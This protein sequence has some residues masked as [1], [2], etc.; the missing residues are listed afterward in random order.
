MAQ[1][2]SGDIV[3]DACST[4]RGIWIWLMWTDPEHVAHRWGPHGMKTRVDGLDLRIGGSWRYVML[5]PNGGE[6]P[7]SVVFSEIVPPERLVMS[8]KFEIS[9]DEPHDGIM[10]QAAAQLFSAQD[11][12]SITQGWNSNFDSPVEI[13]PTLAS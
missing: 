8:A 13:L 5:M 6:Y 1:E 4:R 3:I 7:Q 11:V 2:G 10:T 12:V 9:P